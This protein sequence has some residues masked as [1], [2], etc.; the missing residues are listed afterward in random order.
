MHFCLHFIDDKTTPEVFCFE[1][2]ELI[3]YLL[4]RKCLR[5]NDRVIITWASI[6]ICTYN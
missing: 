2:F 5:T 6:G 4:F 3:K 1:G